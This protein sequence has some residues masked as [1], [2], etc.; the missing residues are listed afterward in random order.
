MA[1]RARYLLE[2]MPGAPTKGGSAS[3]HTLAGQGARLCEDRARA[4]QLPTRSPRAIGQSLLI[5]TSRALHERCSRI[6][7]KVGSR[8]LANHV[9]GNDE[10]SRLPPLGQR[11]PVKWSDDRWLGACD[12]GRWVGACRSL[13]SA[14]AANLKALFLY[15]VGQLRLKLA[16]GIV[17]R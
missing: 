1:I 2:L 8:A 10:E 15:I 5:T 4:A 12:T 11:A 14:A 16:P 13:A 17:R 7:R 6:G 9:I 3:S